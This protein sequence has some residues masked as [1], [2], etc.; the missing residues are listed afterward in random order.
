MRYK[1]FTY[2]LCRV[3]THRAKPAEITGIILTEPI[4]PHP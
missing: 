4:P 2:P 3:I 1:V